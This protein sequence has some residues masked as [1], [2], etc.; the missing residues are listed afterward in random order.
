MQAHGCQSSDVPR[1]VHEPHP[2][3]A[4][5]GFRLL[6]EWGAGA[7]AVVHEAEHLATGRRVAL[8]RLHPHA[9]SGARARLRTE[10]A[11]L[12]E[13]DSDH[14]VRLHED[15]SLH[16]FFTMDLLEGETLDRMASEPLAPARVLEIVSPLARALEAVH[17]HGIV[18][19]DLKPENVIVSEGMCG[20]LRVTMLDFGIARRE[21]HGS[22][23]S[24]E[25]FGTPLYMSPEQ[26]MGRLGIERTSDVWSLGQLVY[27]L[28]AGRPLLPDR[29]H[30]AHLAAR[31]L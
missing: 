23:Q 6:S 12:A 14:V 5:R 13:L 10:A 1:D 30:S 28:L 2:G 21:R 15:H 19:C 18:H 9:S 16:G 31:G 17:S 3:P 27:R 11:L 8:K 25:R 20:T 26:A 24:S 4:E 29:A 22:G 7:S